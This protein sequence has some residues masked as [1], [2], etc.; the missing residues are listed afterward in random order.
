MS[1]RTILHDEHFSIL[2]F[3]ENPESAPDFVVNKFGTPKKLKPS[4]LFSVHILTLIGFASSFLG[5][6]YAAESNVGPLYSLMHSIIL[7][8]LWGAFLNCS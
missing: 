5:H 2:S 7:N 1:R 3:L 6:C 4:L 8:T